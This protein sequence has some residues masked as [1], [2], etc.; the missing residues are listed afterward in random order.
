MSSRKRPA[1]VPAH[2]NSTT[3]GPGSTGP[4]VAFL[5]ATT[6]VV[7]RLDAEEP[8]GHIARLVGGP[9]DR[10]RVLDTVLLW[11]QDT[12]ADTAEPN[13]NA[14]LCLTRLLRAI[15]DGACPAGT[16]E[17]AQ[18][19]RMLREETVPLIFG[20]CVLTGRTPDGDLTSLDDTVHAWLTGRP[21]VLLTPT[22]HR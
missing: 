4:L 3:D 22:R 8:A 10:S 1:H 5:G 20:D 11:V 7:G 15:A 17:R 9:L 12:S 18:A 21:A 6:C 19:H 14:T 13:L 2:D 16:V